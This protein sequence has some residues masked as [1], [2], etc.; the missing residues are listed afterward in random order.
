MGTLLSLLIFSVSHFRSSGLDCLLLMSSSSTS[1]SPPPKPLR[2]S[3][4]PPVE[5]KENPI[6]LAIQKSQQHGQLGSLH[7]G[8]LL[9]RV[10]EKGSLSNA[11]PPPP[12]PPAPAQPAKPPSRDMPPTSPSSP[13]LP[14]PKPAKPLSTSSTSLSSG[15]SPLSSSPPPPPPP[16]VGGFTKSQSVRSSATVSSSDMNQRDRD[17]EG[18]QWTVKS[19][20]SFLSLLRRSEVLKG[21]YLMD[22][23]LAKRNR[24][25]VFEKCH[26]YLTPTHLKYHKV[27]LTGGSSSSA[28]VATG[29]GEEEGNGN[30]RS[31][32]LEFILVQSCQ[33]EDYHHPEKR[34]RCF[35][36]MSKTK[37]F[38][39][40][41]V[42]TQACSE[43]MAALRSAIT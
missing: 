6:A 4:P 42:T 34:D 21:D 31:I 1:P 23:L 3:P 24:E 10:D 7:Q 19:R 9:K 14:L 30:L 28:A 22:G 41:A 16:P 20:G 40:K 29:G 13:P 43:W 18:S 2:R 38:L 37:S 12:P 11:P 32:A 26:F 17:S 15:P 33:V 25:G 35:R 27:S 5:K 36:L 39:L 8:L